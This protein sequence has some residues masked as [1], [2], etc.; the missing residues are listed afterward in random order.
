V[1][2]NFNIFLCIL[3]GMIF[4]GVSVGFVIGYYFGYFIDARQT[5]NVYSLYL[6]A[7]I[8][9]LGCALSIYGTLYDR[10]NPK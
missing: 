6:A 8:L 7:P 3:L 2:I 5:G 9:G 1:K 4:L 10:R